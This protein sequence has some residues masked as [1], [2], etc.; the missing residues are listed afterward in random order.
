MT[1]LIGI[2]KFFAVLLPVIFEL[3]KQ[4]EVPGFGEKKKKA[5]LDAIGLFCDEWLKIGSLAWPKEKILEVV[6][7]IID[8]IVNVYNLLGIFK[9]S[10]NPS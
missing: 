9:H 4:F 6:G 1:Q 2:V 10:T 3:I 7:K 5:V 8:I